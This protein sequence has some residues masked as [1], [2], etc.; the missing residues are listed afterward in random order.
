[1]KTLFRLGMLAAVALGP[2]S[3]RADWKPIE[4]EETYAITGTTEPELYMSIGERGPKIWSG[5]V[6]AH[7]NFALTWTRKYEPKADGACV[8]SQA[9]PKLIITYTIPKPASPLS[10]TVKPRWETFIT[11]VRDHEKVHGQFIKDMVREIEAASVG[12]TVPNDPKCKAIRAEL[13]KRLGPISARK[14]KR[15]A[16]FDR[17][18]MSEGGN[19]RRLVLAFVNNNRGPFQQ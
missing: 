18:E 19:V 17:T 11:G 13:T 6:I 3:A 15:D 4:R 10:P 14:G 2:I 9:T 7:T 16:E 1:M 12:L 5:R 8:L